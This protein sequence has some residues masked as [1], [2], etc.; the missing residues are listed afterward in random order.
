MGHTRIVETVKG[1][2]FTHQKPS[3][4]DDDVEA[5]ARENAALRI[6]RA[7]RARKRRAYL[8][9][10]FLWTD[11][12]THARFQV[13]RNAAADGKNTAK[14]RW[15]R[16]IFLAMRL[17]DGNRLLAD[18]GVEDNGAER[19]F[20]ET[21]HWLELI[22]GKHRYG[23]NLKY[24]HR[25]WQQEDTDENFFHWLDR[26]GGRALSL[27]ECPREQLERERI[28]Y[29]A[30]AQRL[31]Y[32]VQIDS[33]GKLRWARTGE[34]VDTTPG[35]W[36]DGGHGR[37]IVSIPEGENVAADQDS[38]TRPRTP[39]SQHAGED[40][41]FHYYL[42]AEPSKMSNRVK[43]WLWRNFTPRGLLERLLRATIQ[44]DTWIY[45]SDKHFNIFIGIKTP[46]MFQHSSL[47]G[48]GLVTSA[49]LISVHEGMIHKLS[50]LSGHYRTSTQHFR[51]FITALEER[52]VD[53][54]TVHISRAEMALWG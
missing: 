20:L 49:G 4:T 5:L 27:K 52:G 25:R 2:P 28:A 42:P 44:K 39:A 1:C 51:R 11:L 37:G 10:D 14:V 35:R 33:E 47:L 32:L 16:A 8:G 26:G 7:W 36:K 23:S 30:P 46:G 29:L 41:T 53:M 34:L 40:M 17:Q 13:D 15:R 19:K 12:I 9:T 24:Y 43:R 31:N 54:A 50:P 3:L 48:G 38:D 22:D 18:T 21:Q 45:V 6:Q